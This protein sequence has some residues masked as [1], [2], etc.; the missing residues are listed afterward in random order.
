M[1]MP[2]LTEGSPMALLEAM[3]AGRAIVA[4]RV[5]GIPEILEDRRT[6]LLVPAK[7][8]EALAQA[9]LELLTHQNTAVYLGG[10]AELE[11]KKYDVRAATKRIEAIY[12]S[13]TSPHSHSLQADGD[14]C[15]AI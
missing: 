12:A 6:A 3:A 13:L 11:V 15:D 9:I 8:S 14:Y 2:S 4:T 10:N 5:G 1:V 7:N